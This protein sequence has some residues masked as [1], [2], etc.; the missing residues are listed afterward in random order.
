MSGYRMPRIPQ[1]DDDP[2]EIPEHYEQPLLA[3]CRWLMS[4][5][6]GIYTPAEVLS[7]ERVYRQEVSSYTGDVHRPPY[8]RAVNP[9]RNSRRQARRHGRKDQTPNGLT[10]NT[11]I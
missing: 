10:W 7:Y 3:A 1:E 4:G 2:I 11:G 9:F 6:M 8:D 5:L